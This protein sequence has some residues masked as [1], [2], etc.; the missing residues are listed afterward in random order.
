MEKKRFKMYKK[1]KTWVVAPIVFLGILGAAA[2][3]TDKNTAYA[4]E[5]MND[6]TVQVVEQAPAAIESS[7]SSIQVAGENSSVSSEASVTQS[8][9]QAV[10]ASEQETGEPLVTVDAAQSESSKPL[11]EATVATTSSDESTDDTTSERTIKDTTSESNDTAE[12]ETLVTETT[13]ESNEDTTVSK[14]PMIAKSLTQSKTSS[15]VTVKKAKAFAVKSSLAVKAAPKAAPKP[16]S[17]PKI[18][19]FRVYNPNS[20]EHLH[21]M[22]SYEKDHLVRLGWRYEG[23]SMVVSNTGKQLLRI[24]NPNSGEHHFTLNSNEITMLK[25][26]GW[27]YEGVAWLTPTSGV[28]MYRVFNPNA[29]GAGS[30]HYTMNVSERNKLL[31]VGWRNEGVAWYTLGTKSRQ[32]VMLDWF[33]A[34][35]GKVTYSMANRNGPN[36]YDCSSAVFY[37]LIEAGYLSPNTWIGNTDTLFSYEGKLFKAISRNEVRRGDVFVA[38]EKGSSGGAFGHTGVATSGNTIIHC[39]YKDNGISETVI[40]NRTGDPCYWFRFI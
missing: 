21:T 31:N 4:A 24:Y 39:N 3:S 12:Q 1:K 19:I 15:T 20:G 28:A 10:T 26:A 6:Q 11:N 8:S 27:R 32:E 9:D 36:S 16:V 40:L 14:V 23:I 38:G 2:F 18:S 7:E 30:H 13:T 33:Y 25:R 22:N 5:T 34:R 17:V 37:S 35:K 29:R